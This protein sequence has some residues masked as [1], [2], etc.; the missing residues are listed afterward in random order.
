MRKAVLAIVL[1][2]SSVCFGVLSVVSAAS[3]PATNS[4]GSN[5]TVRSLEPLTPN[6]VSSPLYELPQVFEHGNCS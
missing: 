1:A 5:P 4:V 2:I 6:L 3:A